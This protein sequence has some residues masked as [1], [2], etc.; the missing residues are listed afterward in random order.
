MIDVRRIVR[1][2]RVIA[3]FV[4]LC[5]GL[6]IVAAVVR[7]D[8]RANAD[9]A[10][11][12]A[13][14]A[15]NEP[16]VEWEHPF[17]DGVRRATASAASSELPF[18]PVAPPALGAPSAVYVHGEAPDRAHQ[19]LAL[20]YDSPTYGHFLAIEEP[21]ETTQ[22]QLEALVSTCH[23][24]TGC[25]GTWKVVQ[26]GDGTRA[27]LISSSASN[28]VLWLHGGARF[29]VYGPPSSFSV[30]A[31]EAVGTTISVASGA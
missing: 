11:A 17:P 7:T 18:A 29:D 8:R 16:A 5:V 10:A 13:V 19:A 6:G 1:D 23:P 3:G 12:H 26:L 27:L 22:A 30:A 28:G 2:R 24:K 31:A 20:V 4:A 25:E 9:R 14:Q 21:N 15:G